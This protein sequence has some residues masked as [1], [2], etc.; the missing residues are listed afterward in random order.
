MI[1]KIFKADGNHK[2]V[3]NV[4]FH[5]TG[6]MLSNENTSYLSDLFNDL[7]KIDQIKMQNSTEKMINYLKKKKFNQMVLYHDKK[8]QLINLRQSDPQM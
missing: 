8:N 5:T 6:F 4:V 3:A 1:E 7:E 2:I